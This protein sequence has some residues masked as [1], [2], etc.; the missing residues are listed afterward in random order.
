[1][2]YP[3]EGAK[4]S[5]AAGSD[6]A[7]QLC[8]AEGGAA[9]MLAAQQQYAGPNQPTVSQDDIKTWGTPANAY[10][11]MLAREQANKNPLSSDDMQK[12][13]SEVSDIGKAVKAEE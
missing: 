4:Y 8:R 12:A 6:R 1:M 7:K 13:M 5:A 10:N 9:D 3:L 2:P 11:A